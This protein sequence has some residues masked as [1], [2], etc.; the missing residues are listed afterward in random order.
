MSTIPEQSSNA[1]ENGDQINMN[2]ASDIESSNGAGTI[3]QTD[4][5]LQQSDRASDTSSMHMTKGDTDSQATESEN[6]E[7]QQ[8]RVPRMT[9]RWL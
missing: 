6:E 4:S 5:A 9:R 2:L 3:S 8:N 1:S 7:N